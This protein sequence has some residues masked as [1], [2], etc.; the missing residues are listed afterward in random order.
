MSKTGKYR[1]NP[2]TKELEKIS[3]R[4][5]VPAHVWFPKD[6]IHTG[7]YFENLG[8]KHFDSAQEK[9]NYMKEK[10]IAEAG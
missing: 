1:Y 2:V 4:A 8:D 5:S 9:R 10:G 6:S 7:G 3:D